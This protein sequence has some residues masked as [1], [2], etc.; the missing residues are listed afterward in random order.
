MDFALLE[1]TLTIRELSFSP[2]PAIGLVLPTASPPAPGTVASK[3]P[4]AAAELLPCLFSHGCLHTLSWP[5]GISPRFPPLL[6]VTMGRAGGWSC[7]P[8]GAW[9]WGLVFSRGN[10]CAFSG[11]RSR[12]KSWTVFAS[13]VL[14]EFLL[15]STVSLYLTC[16]N[17]YKTAVSWEMNCFYGLSGSPSKCGAY[18]PFSI[19]RVW[20]RGRGEIATK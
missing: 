10:L 17:D 8:V 4:L 6:W 2:H 11:A 16:T 9:Q 15:S 5:T 20:W 1:D 12:H 18:F 7:C 3:I 13:R 14:W 19:H